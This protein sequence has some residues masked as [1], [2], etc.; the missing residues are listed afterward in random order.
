MNDWMKG[1]KITGHET[2]LMVLVLLVGG[3]M[4]AATNLET[5]NS[6]QIGPFGASHG[7]TAS[8]PAAQYSAIQVS[9]PSR[10]AAIA[11]IEQLTSPNEI[12]ASQSLP[13][14]LGT[15]NLPSQDPVTK[16]LQALSNFASNIQQIKSGLQ[17][18]EALASSGNQNEALPIVDHLAGLENQT[19]T[20]LDTL[21]SLLNQIQSEPKV[22]LSRIQTIKQRLE[23]LGRIYVEYAIEI[24]Q[25]KSEITP[26]TVSLDISLSNATVYVTEPLVVTGSLLTRNGTAMAQRNITITW[27]GIHLTVP[28]DSNGTY[29]ATVAFPLGYPNGTAIV[30]A[31]FH[32][33]GPDAN[34]FVTTDASALTQLEYYPT[35]ITAQASSQLALPLE[36][37]SVIGTLTTATGTPLENRT[38]HILLDNDVVGDI[39]TTTNGTYVFTLHVPPSIPDGNH[40][41]AVSF[42]PAAEIYAPAIASLPLAVQ[43]E[44]IAITAVLAASVPLSGTTL[45]VTGAVSFAKTAVNQ[46]TF[47][48]NATVLF[49]GV[50]YGSSTV[51]DD[52][53]FSL[54]VPIP[55][56]ASFGPHSVEVVYVPVDPQIDTSTQ[57]I[58]VYVYNSEFVAVAVIAAVLAP[59]L[60]IAGRKRRRARRLKSE[61]IEVPEE[62]LTV[63]RELKPPMT[64]IEWDSALWIAQVERDPSRKVVMCY[65]LGRNLIANKFNESIDDSETHLEFC[66]RVVTLKPLLGPDLKRLVELFEFA[67]YSQFK[68]SV[69]EGNEALERL[70]KIRDADWS[71]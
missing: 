59:E 22:D 5:V 51:G 1:V 10:N 68:A 62:P 6:G 21:Y 67:E 69:Y 23:G 53:V 33:V 40:T 64:T 15:S 37:V 60:V 12:I 55:L 39:D 61:V 14:V 42:V 71:S 20:L 30:G 49:D 65:R 2:A 66:S 18:A 25:L 57:T 50:R 8:A 36:S 41:L 27:A 63:F 17:T 16:Y 31:S 70:L 3:T 13:I 35:E 19:G 32:P 9:S 11:A 4:L 45:R 38:L 28:T 56:G 48:G 46:G 43:R 58:Q 29:K 44:P 47:R 24:D 54:N 26:K 34:L 7:P 52:G